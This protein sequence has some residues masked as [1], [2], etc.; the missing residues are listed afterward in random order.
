MTP[1]MRWP[2]NR[3]RLYGGGVWVLAAGLA[4][5]G[6][7]APLF[8]L[9]SGRENA[10]VSAWGS[11]DEAGVD[12]FPDFG[13]PIIVG[14]VFI[15]IAAVL[16]MTSTR[17]HPASAPVLGA[18]LLGT[19]AAGL[20]IGTT[21]TLYLVKVL[22]E[23]ATRGR[24]NSV[25]SGLGMWLLIASAVVGV[26]GTVLMLIP[27]TGR[28]DPDPETPPMGIPIVRVL[29]PEYDELPFDAQ[30]FDPQPEEKKDA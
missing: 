5:G 2:I 22:F 21:V 18:R 4:V 25:I 12:Y 23:D 3:L 24:N 7:F 9:R 8:E 27:K 16:A 20:L 28:P 11:D 10:V 13:V 19:G 17:L 1:P 30:P 29:E 14:V 15:A 26:A 6:T